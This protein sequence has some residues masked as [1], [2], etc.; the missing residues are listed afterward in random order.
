MGNAKWF[1]H[2][3]FEEM[4][5]SPEP[6]LKLELRVNREK[7]IFEFMEPVYLELKLT[8]ISSQPVLVDENILLLSDSMTVIIKKNG[9]DARQLIP[10]AQFCMKPKKEALEPG[11]AIY[12]P[13]F[14]SAGLNGWD[15]AEPGYY[16]VQVALRIDEE[17]IVSNA[18]KVCIRPPKSYDEEILAQDFFSDEI[19]R[20]FT[21]SGSGFFTSANDTLREVVK[22]LPKSRVALHAAF[23]LGNTIAADRKEL[24]IEDPTTRKINGRLQKANLDEAYKLIETAFITKPDVAIETFGHIGFADHMGRISTLFEGQGATEKAVKI[25]GTLF[26]TM[27]TRKVNGRPILKTVVNKIQDRLKKLKGK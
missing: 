15:I 18:L 8:N 11:K 24:V 22:K 10:F 27:S 7:A 4:N 1:D 13:L 9:K 21:F 14:I 12:G 26:A 2:H 23:V 5:L 17:D 16:T 3:G 25:E 6:V 20:I 19:G